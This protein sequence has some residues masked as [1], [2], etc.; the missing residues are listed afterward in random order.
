[1]RG[2]RRFGFCHSESGRKPGEEPA[3][4]FVI[5]N[6]AQS[7]VRNLLLLLSF[8]TGLKAPPKILVIPNRAESPVRNLL[9]PP[10]NLTRLFP[11]PKL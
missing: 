4:A 9:F 5:P 10:T 2:T 8:R 6:R 3:F 7:P 11:Q 1:M